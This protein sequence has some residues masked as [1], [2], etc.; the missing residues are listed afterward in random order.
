MP[1]AILE[2]IRLSLEITLQILKDM[3]PAEKVKAW[4]RHAKA[5]EFWEKLFD[6]VFKAETGKP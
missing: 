2:I 5:M 4:E 3:P 6:N 1:A